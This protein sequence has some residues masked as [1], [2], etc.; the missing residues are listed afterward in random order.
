[1]EFFGN[2][3]IISFLFQKVILKNGFLKPFHSDSKPVSKNKYTRN[4][5]YVFK[6]KKMQIQIISAFV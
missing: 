6:D 4:Q 3:I 1:M 5:V 2:N